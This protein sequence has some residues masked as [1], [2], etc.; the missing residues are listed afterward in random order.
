M[1]QAEALQTLLR[2]HQ[3]LYN[4]ALEERISAW[5]KKQISISYADQC[6]SLTEIRQALPEWRLANCSS[7]QMT[8]R[9]LNKAY[10]AFFR[11]LHAGEKPGFP[12]FKSLSRFPGIS[13]KS[14]GDGWEFK[15][16][17]NW[18]HGSLRLSGI[19][20]VVCRGRAREGGMIA[21]S[22]ICYRRGEWTL[23]LTITPSSI[24]RSRTGHNVLALDWGVATLLTGIND[25]G[26]TLIVENPRLYQKHKER[27]TRLQQGLARKARGSKRHIDNARLVSNAYAKLG[28]IRLEFQHQLTSRL[29]RTHSVIAMEAL[30]VKEMTR[31]KKPTDDRGCSF[32]CNAGLH[33]EI[34]DTAPARLMQLLRY[35]VI[36]TGGTWL[37]APT[38]I[39]KPSQ[40]CPE[41]GQVK[42]KELSERVHACSNCDY[43]APRDLAS[44]RVVLNWA[45][46]NETT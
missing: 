14:H 20:H 3:V 10:M 32:A 2:S 29:A 18:Q 45:L 22:D 8:L 15:P 1:Q 41:C 30:A 28:R 16:G 23:S 21:A 13:F 42:K 36:D 4:A 44:A 26:E 9:R 25:L 33:R 43:V 39:L 46:R 37:V 6:K 17:D 27:I 12:R 11:R 40:T 35:K 19:G 34:L 31:W 5:Q 7:Q 24:S 38:R